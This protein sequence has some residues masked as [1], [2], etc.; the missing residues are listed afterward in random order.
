MQWRGRRES[1]NVED[2]RGS[3]GG[4]RGLALGGVGTIVVVIIGL[5]MGKNPLEL[6]QVVTQNAGA[7]TEQTEPPQ[8]S[9]R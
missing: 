8:Q 4:R 1:G 9:C 7:P 2:M 5:I 6:L 3:G